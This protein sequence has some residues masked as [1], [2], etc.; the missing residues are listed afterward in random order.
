MHVNSGKPKCQMALPLFHRQGIFRVVQILLAVCRSCRVGV[1]INAIVST[2]KKTH[3]LFKL[4]FSSATALR[5]PK[6]KTGVT[7]KHSP[8]LPAK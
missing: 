2:I 7:A 6:L 8:P 5:R 4:I 1:L 3:F